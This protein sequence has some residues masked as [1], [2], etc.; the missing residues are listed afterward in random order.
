MSLVD[1]ILSY[2]VQWADQLA[3]NAVDLYFG[4]LKLLFFGSLSRGGWVSAGSC[5][6]WETSSRRRPSSGLVLAAVDS[7]FSG[8]SPAV[9]WSPEEDVQVMYVTLLAAMMEGLSSANS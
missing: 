8:V 5:T 9:V 3:S 6:D 4:I 1:F 7:F 2:P